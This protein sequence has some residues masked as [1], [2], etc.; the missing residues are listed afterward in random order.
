MR[1]HTTK[2]MLDYWMELFDKINPDTKAE[3]KLRWP[4]RSDIQPSTCRDLLGDMFILNLEHGSATYRLAGTRLCSLFGRELKQEDYSAVFQDIDIRAA[5]NWAGSIGSDDFLVLI[6][7]DGITSD[8]EILPL[9]TL[10][11]PLSQQGVSNRRAL[12]MTVPLTRPNWIGSKPIVEQ[13]IRS[14]RI[15]R[16]WEEN[17]FKTNRPIEHSG[18]RPSSPK[19]VAAFNRLGVAPITNIGLENVASASTSVPYLRVLEGGKQ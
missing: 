19:P 13:R 14:V 8:G 5:S 17:V 2:A 10:L 7:A 12:G 18:F 6:C 1:N 11:M 3:Q 4:E 16:P 9:E 15:I